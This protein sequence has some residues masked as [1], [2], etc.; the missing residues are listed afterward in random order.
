[1][2]AQFDRARGKTIPACL[3]GIEKSFYRGGIPAAVLHGIDLMIHPGECVFLA[4]PS[5]SGKTTLMSILG[6]ILSADRGRVRL[7]GEDLQ[8]MEE[9]ERLAMRRDRVGFVFQRFHL[10]RGLSAAENVGV[11]LTLQG[12][13]WPTA[14]KQAIA[15]LKSVGMEQYADADPSRMSGGQC[16]R[17]ALA[18]ALVGRPELVLAD[19][20]TASLDAEN[21]REVMEL[22][23]RLTVHEG[24]AAVVVTHDPRIFRYADRII[25]LEDGRIVGEDRAH[26]P[27]AQDEREAS[28]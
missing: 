16:Q 14:R 7:F 20:P 2:I 11:P 6:G 23:R 3:E 22:L 25:R 19:E 15:V 5:G 4:G 10:I 24:K 9:A 27:V 13:S 18:R 8:R 26:E 28:A 17:I 1:M 21:G 12:S